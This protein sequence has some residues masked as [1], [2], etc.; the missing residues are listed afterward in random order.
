MRSGS[1]HDSAASLEDGRAGDEDEE[2]HDGAEVRDED[3]KRSM[4]EKEGTAMVKVYVSFIESTLEQM[5]VSG[6]ISAEQYNRLYS[7]VNEEG[8]A[9]RKELLEAVGCFTVT[10]D[11]ESV[12]EGVEG[13]V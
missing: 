13:E 2:A 10:Y 1:Q 11:V 7:A 5:L 6:K 4:L 3:A 9:V 12:G 8:G